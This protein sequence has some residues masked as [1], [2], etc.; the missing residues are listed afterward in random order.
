MIR[1]T[2]FTF[3]TLLIVSSAFINPIFTIKSKNYMKSSNNINN[4]EDINSFIDLNTLNN[5]IPSNYLY[6]K[7][8]RKKVFLILIM[9]EKN[10]INL[11]KFL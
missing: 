6:K 4:V 11:V 5:E 1:I 2:L 10:M 3:S 8:L 7:I 9:L